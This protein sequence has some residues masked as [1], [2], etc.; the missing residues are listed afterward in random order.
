[1]VKNRFSCYFLALVLTCYHLKKG[2]AT[3]YRPE[4]IVASLL[5]L[6]AL[7]FKVIFNQTMLNSFSKN[8]SNV[9]LNDFLLFTKLH[10]LYEPVIENLKFVLQK[11]SKMIIK[12]SSLLL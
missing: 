8:I 11:I 5:L 12:K 2:C 6:M 3:F 9:R 1:M 4:T 7:S 10:E